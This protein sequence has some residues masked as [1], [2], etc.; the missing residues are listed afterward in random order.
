MV[1][2]NPSHVSNLTNLFTLKTGSRTGLSGFEQHLASMLKAESGTSTNGTQNG[3][4]SGTN[5]TPTMSSN[6]SNSPVAT[7]P[8]VSTPKAT[9]AATAEETPTDAYWA[10]Q[11]AAVQALR[12]APED[13]KGA[14]AE[15]LAQQGYQIDVPIMVWGWDPLAT[16]I[17]RQEEGYTWVPSAL[18]QNVAS[19]PGVSMPGSAPYNPDSA[20]AGSIQVSTAFADGTNIAADPVAQ[21][22][23]KGE[24]ATTS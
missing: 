7:S 15:Q 13:Q 16:M 4:T 20:P 11:P 2:T 5:S 24:S 10:A 12:Y 18:Q 21:L 23:L 9:V 3:T 17:Q 14:M 6:S 1:I 19:A 22:W 8:A